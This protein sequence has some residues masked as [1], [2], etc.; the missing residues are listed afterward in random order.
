NLMSTDAEHISQ[1]LPDINMTWSAP[2]VLA[3]AMYF[4]WVELGWAMFAG[5]AVLVLIIPLN[6]WISSCQNR[7]QTKQ[8]EE[9]DERV[10]VINEV[11]GGIRVIKLY[12]WEVPFIGK[13][14]DIRAREVRQ[15]RNV[16]YANAVSSILWR[17]SP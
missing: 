7:Y 5:F 13:I 8:M 9:K 15:I 6:A 14:S 3:L 17:I 16:A 4:L 10:K 12:G 1:V 11:L 2:Y